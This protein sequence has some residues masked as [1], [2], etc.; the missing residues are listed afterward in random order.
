LSGT[1]VRLARHPL[2]RLRAIFNERAKEFAV[3]SAASMLAA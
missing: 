1:T 2:L 3:K